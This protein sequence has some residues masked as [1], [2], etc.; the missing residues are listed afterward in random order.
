MK[1][2]S[3]DKSKLLVWLQQLEK[4]FEVIAPQVHQSSWAFLPTHGDYSH[5]D[6]NYTTSILPA[7]KVLIPQK[8]LLFS[9]DTE[10]FQCNPSFD[11]SPKILFGVHTCDLHAIALL[12]RVFQTGYPDQHYLNRRQNLIIISIECLQPCSEYAFCRDMN[13]LIPRDQF[14]LHLTD[15][16]DTY[17]VEIGSPSGEKLVEDRSIFSIPDE[18]ELFQYK[19]IIKTK[20]K[21]FQFKLNTDLFELPELLA[22]SER[23][24]LWLDLGERCLGCGVC[25]IVCPTCFC[26]D[27]YDEISLSLDQGERYRVWDSCQLNRFSVVAGGHDFRQSQASR[28]KHRFFHKYKYTP[29]LYNLPGCVGC[30]RCTH[31]CPVRINPIDTLN[32]LNNRKLPVSK[33]QKEVILV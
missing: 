8:E 32:Q 18:M 29:Q 15:L 27:V 10:R 4:S 3:I 5:V 20:W 24:T 9:F 7:K 30:G 21:S 26:F 6:L 33:R 16:G 13:T 17:L 31:Y 2:N 22:L 23:S 28:L 14:D 1:F 11:S 12:D 25:T 19:K